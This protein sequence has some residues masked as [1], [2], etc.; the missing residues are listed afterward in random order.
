MGPKAKGG[1]VARARG[2]VERWGQRLEMGS[3]ARGGVRVEGSTP[4]SG[5]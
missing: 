5:F 1:M 4:E 3:M 2:R